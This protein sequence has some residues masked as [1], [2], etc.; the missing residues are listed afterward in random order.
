MR[1][2]AT[3]SVSFSS[4]SSFS[5]F[6]SAAVLA[7]CLCS[8]GCAKSSD[9]PATQAAFPTQ[10]PAAPA[11]QAPGFGNGAAQPASPTLAAS[12]V[13]APATQLS[14]PGPLAL[15]CTTDAQCLT[16]RCNVSAGKCA[17]PCQTD[18]D[19]IPGMSCIAPTCLPKLQ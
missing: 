8:A 13:G 5:S 2:T 4:F 11:Q 9:Q 19:C 7:W 6:G 17:W 14:Q 15:P 1:I 16:H 18:N 12:P 3:L 10:A